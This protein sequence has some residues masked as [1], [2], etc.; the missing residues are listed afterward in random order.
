M[1]CRVN[2][3]CKYC[4][5]SS[6]WF[7]RGARDT[8]QDVGMEVWQ[9]EDCENL[10]NSLGKSLPSGSSAGSCVAL[11]PQEQ[12]VKD[13]AK[14]QVSMPVPEGVTEK[15]SIWKTTTDSAAQWTLIEAEVSN[16]QA[17]FQAS[18]GGVYVPRKSVNVAAIVGIVCAVSVLLIIVCGT[19][20]YFCKYPEKWQ[21]LKKGVRQKANYAKRSMQSQV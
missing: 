10:I 4:R 18:E 17:T 7:D 6:V 14:F 5:D 1:I 3:T 20:I 21:A 2:F 11:Y 9:T 8:P 19:T 15:V 13:S 16:G 12:L